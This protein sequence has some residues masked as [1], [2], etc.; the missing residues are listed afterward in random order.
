VGEGGHTVAILN[1]APDCVVIGL[2]RDPAALAIAHERLAGFGD[3][4]RLVNASY[5]T[6]AEQGQFLEDRPVTGVLLD[7][8]LSSLQV[9][10]GERGFSFLRDGPLDM[11]FGP[12][13]KFT[14][15]DV[16]NHFAER[17]LVRLL[18]EFGEEPRA[19]RIARAIVQRRPIRGT[20]Q[21]AEVVE[22]TLG[23]RGRI[24]PATRT[25]QGIRIEVNQELQALKTVLSAAAETL[26]PGGRLVVISYHSLED[27]LVKTTLRE[28]TVLR[29][30]TK[31]PIAP[32]QEEVAYNP[33]SRSARMRAAERLD[34]GIASK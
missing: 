9:E 4:V 33:R 2:D 29:V 20:A 5:T 23:R 24:H 27:R 6:L 25:F 14:A 16:V 1:A 31:K 11:R 18:F 15:D 3:R 19:R 10:D 7:L 21:L 28:S 34:G 12:D 17:D 8:G 13:E 30:L 26:Q 22:G 32:S